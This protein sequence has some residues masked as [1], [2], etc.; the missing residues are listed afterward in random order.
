MRLTIKQ[1]VKR[2]V[3]E[4]KPKKEAQHVTKAMKK[5]LKIK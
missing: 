4:E 2:K 1:M 5:E 3:P